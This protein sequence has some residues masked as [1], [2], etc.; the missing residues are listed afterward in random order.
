MCGIFEKA[1][2]IATDS[3]AS[4]TAP[5]D[6]N[7]RMVKGRSNPLRPHLVQVLAGGKI[8]CDENCPVTACHCVY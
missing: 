1:E 6:G 2:E 8:V 4:T 5:V 3:H 7:A